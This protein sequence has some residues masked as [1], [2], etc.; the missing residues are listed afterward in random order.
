MDLKD[1]DIMGMT[2]KTLLSSETI[3]SIFDIMDEPERARIIAIMTARAKEFK[4][5]S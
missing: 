2:P 4:M 1:N 5:E 3:Y